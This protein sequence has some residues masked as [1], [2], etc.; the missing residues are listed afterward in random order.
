MW[1][2]RRRIGIAELNPR[3]L[4]AHCATVC[5]VAVRA[6]GG[7]G[8]RAIT[9]VVGRT[10]VHTGSGGNSGDSRRNGGTSVQCRT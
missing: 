1:H 10:S 8:H 5:E 3:R 2:S 7:D 4:V 6:V 9:T